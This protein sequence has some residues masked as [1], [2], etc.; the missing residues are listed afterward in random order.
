MRGTEQL[1]K[2]SSEKIKSVGTGAA[3]QVSAL[4]QGLNSELANLLPC[5]LYQSDRS[6]Q[7]SYISETIEEL[8]GVNSRAAV[9]N[10]LFWD[11]RV[12]PEDLSLVAGKLEELQVSGS[13]ALIHRMLDTRE[14]PV[15]VCHSMKLARVDREEV[16]FGSLTA[17]GSDS[18]VQQVDSSVISRFVHKIGNHFQL[19]NLVA[20]SISKTLPNPRDVNVLQEAIDR[21]IDLVRTFSDYSQIPACLPHMDLAD[22]IR[23]AIVTRRRLF[24][25]K[26][27]DLE[28]KIGDSLDD[29]T[30]PGDPFLLENA[31]G[32]ILQNALEATQAG[33][34]VSVIGAIEAPR[35]HSSVAKLRVSDTGCGIDKNHL[36]SV[37]APFFTSKK[38]HEGL[39]LS[40]SSRFVEVHGGVLKIRSAVGQGTEVELSLPVITSKKDGL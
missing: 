15:W 12:F 30:I 16:L 9:E 35:D 18:K 21:A 34:V 39:G 24:Q 8:L 6:L 10:R 37:T 2:I 11:Q 40:L 5:V 32:H 36:A 31:I 26:G 17:L 38:D 20:G 7:L 23:T 19:I 14:L 3:E 4:G 29:A 1:D 22:V 28:E 13:V 25:H 33:G 27:V